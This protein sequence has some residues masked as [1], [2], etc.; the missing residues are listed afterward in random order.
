[1]NYTIPRANIFMEVWLSQKFRFDFADAKVTIY[2][3]GR[4]SL[5][6]GF[7]KEAAQFAFLVLEGRARNAVVDV[8][9]PETLSPLEVVRMCDQLGERRFINYAQKMLSRST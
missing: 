1:M 7:Y 2:G 5:S 6:W 8:G 3:S 4:H 9:G